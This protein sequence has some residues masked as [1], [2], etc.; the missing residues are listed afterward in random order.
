MISPYALIGFIV[1]SLAYIDFATIAVHA[2]PI[3]DQNAGPQSL[4]IPNDKDMDI[5]PFAGMAIKGPPSPP[6]PPT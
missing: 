3:P 2:L 4:T 6:G 1:I 5:I